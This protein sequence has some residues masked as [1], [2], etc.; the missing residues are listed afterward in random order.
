MIKKV[1]TAILCLTLVLTLGGCSLSNRPTSV[2]AD[3]EVTSSK[4]EPVVKSYINPLTGIDNLSEGTIDRRP[5]AI[6]VNNITQ[7]QRVQTGLG[8]ADIVYETEVEGGVTRLMAVFKD[9]SKASQVGTIRS[10]R[11]PY[12]DLAL[13]HDA[14]YVHCGQ[15]PTYCKPHLNDIDD[16][17]ID[18]NSPGAKRIK[19]G[20]A[21]EHTLYVF[22]EKL[23]PA[24]ASKFKSTVKNTSWQNF[25]KEDETV[26]LTGGRADRVTVPFPILKTVFDYDK[27]TGLYTRLSQNKVLKDYVTGKPITVKNVFVL[28]TNIADYPDHYHR[29]VDLVGGAGYYVTNGTYTK[30]KWQKGSST[31]PIKITDESGKEIEVSAGNSWVCIANT[32]TCKPVMESAEP[33]ATTSTPSNP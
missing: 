23:W 6:M 19:N 26:T 1:F 12:V 2:D 14:I 7:A 5:V 17:S 33:T 11:Y 18:T 10:A 29:K 21:T 25:A 28:M 20:L 27:T 30:I 31:S 8:G 24:L 22:P 15:D 13:G 3:S 16:L 9:F 32:A 4:E